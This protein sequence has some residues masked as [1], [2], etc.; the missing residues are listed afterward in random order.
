M[1]LLTSAFFL[2]AVLS[3]AATFIAARARFIGTFTIKPRSPKPK[4][5]TPMS[6]RRRFM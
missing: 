6:F 1:R 4:S 5:N 3:N 2:S